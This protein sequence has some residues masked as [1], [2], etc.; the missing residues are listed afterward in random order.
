MYSAV[1]RLIELS[2]GWNGRV[3]STQ[4]YFSECH[5]LSFILQRW[6][7]E[8][9]G[10]AVG[11]LL[12]ICFTCFRRARWYDGCA[13]DHHLERSPPWACASSQGLLSVLTSGQSTDG[14]L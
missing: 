4:V 7:F 2:D 8:T 12:I 11:R 5:P 3:I 1:Y 10:G 6:I 14:R 13:S 9:S